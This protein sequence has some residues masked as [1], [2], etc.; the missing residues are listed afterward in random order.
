MW[1][2]RRGLIFIDCIENILKGRFDLWKPWLELFDVDKY[3]RVFIF[4]QDCLN[5]VYNAE[6]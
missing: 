5:N 1:A 4:R 3:T 6:V 2:V